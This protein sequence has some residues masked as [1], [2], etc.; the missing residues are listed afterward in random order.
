[1]ITYTLVAVQ[2]K[3]LGPH[4][5]YDGVIGIVWVKEYDGGSDVVGRRRRG[6]ASFQRGGEY[7]A[8]RTE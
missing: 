6:P 8:E 4:G 5:D 2:A 3:G 1:M 7:V